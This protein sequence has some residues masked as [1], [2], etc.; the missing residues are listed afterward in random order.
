M[1]FLE[2]PAFLRDEC[3][4]RINAH[5]LLVLLQYI[6][7]RTTF[8][9]KSRPAKRLLSLASRATLTMPSLAE[10]WSPFVRSRRTPTSRLLF[11]E[12]TLP[13]VQ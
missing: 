5:E 3:M 4:H 12:L 2:T 6:N 10:Q 1:T 7:Y 9:S 13:A 8:R 11:C